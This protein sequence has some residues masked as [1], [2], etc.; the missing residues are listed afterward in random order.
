[1]NI[2]VQKFVPRTLKWRRRADG[3]CSG[4]AIY[5]LEGDFPANGDV[6]VEKARQDIS[7]LDILMV[8]LVDGGNLNKVVLRNTLISKTKTQMRKTI[9]KIQKAEIAKRI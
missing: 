7:S 9:Q 4:S 6:D 1:M 5:L 3:L 2:L 8:L